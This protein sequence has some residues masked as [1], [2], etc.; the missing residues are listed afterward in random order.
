MCEPKRRQQEQ[1]E[2]G[3]QLGFYA[4]LKFYEAVQG[5]SKLKTVDDFVKSPYYRA[6]VK[7]GRYCIDT[8]VIDPED[9]LQWLLQKNKKIDRWT[10]DQ[11][12]TDFIIEHLRKEKADEALRR[13]IEWS[14]KWEEKHSSPAKDCLRFGNS[15]AICY[16]ITAGQLSAWII[17]NCESGR[18]LLESLTSEQLTMIWPYIDSDIWQTKFQNFS[19]DQVFVSSALEDLGW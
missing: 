2:R 17:Y 19:S 13:A 5:S 4:F 10:S 1:P 12:Y 3:V 7:F 6:F 9:Y 15:N 8:K 18:G 16:A 11:L 14:L